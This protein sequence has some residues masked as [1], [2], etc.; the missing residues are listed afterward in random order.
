M[1]SEHQSH[2]RP[3]VAIDAAAAAP[4][5]A[6][7]STERPPVHPR[8]R[9][10]HSASRRWLPLLMI[11]AAARVALG[12]ACDPRALEMY[13]QAV[14]AAKALKQLEYDA[15][16]AGGPGTKD[17]SVAHVQIEFEGRS[18]AMAMVGG[19]RIE[20]LDKAGGQPVETLVVGTED[21]VFLR[22]GP[23]TV[24]RAASWATIGGSCFASVPDW[25]LS[26]RLHGD[27]LSTKWGA[28]TRLASARHLGVRELDGQLCDLVAIEREYDIGSTIKRL[29]KDVSRDPDAVPEHIGRV[30]EWLA[31]G[32]RDHLPRAITVRDAPV[33]PGASDDSPALVLQRLTADQGIEAQRFA[34]VSP[35]GYAVQSPAAPHAGAAPKPGS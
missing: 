24:A 13:G 15:V 26:V 1:T 18:K 21:A 22:H 5:D 16:V 27:F 25:I 34:T 10:I 11:A 3:A 2:P 4:I 23:R 32:Q 33:E 29:G 35:A 14:A 30:R 7:R 9:R 8:L 19:M 12:Q 28:A 6:A 20:R 31:I 17:A